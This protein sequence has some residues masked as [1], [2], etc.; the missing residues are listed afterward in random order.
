MNRQTPLQ[1]TTLQES[2]TIWGMTCSVLLGAGRSKCYLCKKPPT[3][4]FCGH[5][6]P[7]IW[8]TTK[9]KCSTICGLMPHRQAICVTKGNALSIYKPLSETVFKTI[10]NSYKPCHK[11]FKTLFYTVNHSSNPC[12]DPIPRKNTRSH[13]S[14]DF[15]SH[16]WGQLGV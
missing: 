13:G 14:I 9:S 1:N 11:M 15:C 8:T 6:N 7:P 2:S 16:C 3:P 12:F 5:I 10:P 4:L